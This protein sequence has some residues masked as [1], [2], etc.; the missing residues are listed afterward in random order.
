MHALPCASH[1]PAAFCRVSAGITCSFLRLFLSVFYAKKNALSS[2]LSCFYDP[3]FGS[4]LR[5]YSIQ[6]PPIT[7]F[8]S[9][10]GI[11]R[12]RSAAVSSGT[13]L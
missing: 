8:T 6:F 5:K 1:H 11:P 12:C 13:W 7:F 2:I 4:V 10:A 3:F 9:S